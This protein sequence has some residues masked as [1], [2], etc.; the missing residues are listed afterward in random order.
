MERKIKL[1]SPLAIGAVSLGMLFYLVITGQVQADVLVPVLVG[2][3][4]G[5]GG[6]HV[7]TTKQNSE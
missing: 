5:L 1:L 7:G 4:G 6:Y 3:L 2:S